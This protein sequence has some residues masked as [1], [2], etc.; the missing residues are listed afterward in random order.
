MDEVRNLKGNK[1][2]W[3]K[4]FLKYKVSKSMY[5]A[6]NLPLHSNK[7]KIK[8]AEKSTLLR[9]KREVRSLGKVLLPDCKGWQASTENHNLLEQKSRGGN[10]HGNQ[11]EKRKKPKL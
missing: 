10:L 1:I 6:Y 5:E 9:S 7:K 8:Q 4:F 2:Y 11:M 3:I